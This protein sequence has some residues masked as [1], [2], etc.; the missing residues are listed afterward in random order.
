MGELT[1]RRNRGFAVP[2]YQGTAKTEKKAAA[3]QAQSVSR[4]TGFAVSETLR[5]LMSRVS[6]AENQSRESR[7]TLQTGEA[8]LDE[9][10]DRLGRLAEL[11]EKAAGGGASDRAALQAELEQLRGEIDR[12]TGAALAG[13]TP[14]FL[15][16]ELGVED[17]GAALLDA[18]MG[19]TSAAEEN[20]RSLPDWLLKGIAQGDITPERLLAALGLDQTAAGPEIL[21]A[22]LGRPLDGN[23]AAGYLAALYL[24]A[25]I[26]GGSTDSIDPE[27]AMEGLRQLLEKV[28]EGLT[29]DEA[30]EHL[31]N[32]EFTSFED[33]QSQFISGTAPGLQDFLVELLLG[34]GGS[35]LL[36]GPALLAY[37]A[38]LEG[39]NLDLLMSLLTNLQSGEMPLEA[40]A[41]GLAEQSGTDAAAGRAAVLQLGNVQVMGTDLSGVSFDAASGLLTIGGT[42]GVTVQGTGQGGQAILLTGSGAVTLQQADVSTLTIASPEARIFSAGRTPLGEVRLQTGAALTLGGGGLLSVG[43]FRGDGTNVLRLSGG[44]VVLT[45]KNSQT[46]AELGIPVLVEGP[47]PW[48]RGRPGCGTPAGG[49]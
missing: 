13:D 45:E 6:Q 14:L 44:A 8:V 2:P 43:G 35:Q 22:I 42:A 40:D 1:I 7:R 47:R 41:A 29:P 5:Q 36:T 39:M 25:V 31:T 30:I 23:Y 38:G 10:Q 12:M 33:F 9:V 3:G 46:L 28:A 4:T 48:R 11:A 19:E 18:I 26:A 17:G 49:L 24:G 34:E 21:A 15:D 37:L 16:G 20:V 27:Q 32:G